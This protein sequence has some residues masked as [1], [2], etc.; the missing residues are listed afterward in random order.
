MSDYQTRR[1]VVTGI[2]ALTPLGLSFPEFWQNALAGKSG[3]GPI[4]QFDTTDYAVRIAGEV[5]GFAPEN[6]F[7]KKDSRRMDRFIQLGYAATLEAIREARLDLDKTDRD[8]VGILLGSGIGGLPFIE[9]MKATIIARGPDKVSPFLVPMTTVDMASGQISTHLGIRG[10]NFGVVSAC[11]TGNN[12][13]GLGHRFIKYDDCDVCIVGGAEACV[14]TLALSGFA[15]ARALS[16]SNDTPE[17]ACRPFDRDRNGFVIGEGAA[18]FVLEELGHAVRR[19]APILAEVLGF[20]STGDAFHITSPHPD[21]DGAARAMSLAVKE[22]GIRPE[23]VQYINAH[24]TATEVG[25]PAEAMAVKRVFGDQAAKIPASATKSLGGHLLGAAGALGAA[26][27]VQ[28]LLT[29]TI[30]PSINCPNP[31]PA[32]GLNVVTAPT[33]TTVDYAICNAFGFGGHN[34]CLCMGKYKG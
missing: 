3:V 34:T 6:F 30:H 2:G 24:A 33:K 25:D 8:R 16:T 18:V 28:T 14:C 9:E 26:A 19:G 12:S 10:P 11:A 4:T 27:T 17:T 20:A 7:D 5:R 13:I 23:Q 29:D 31:D 15:S 32:L 21:G 1:V 22:A